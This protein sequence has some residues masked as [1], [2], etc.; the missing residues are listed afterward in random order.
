M[1]GSVTC[2]N[3][4]KITVNCNPVTLPAGNPA[5]VDGQL[6]ITVQSGDGTFEYD[7][8]TPLQFKAVSGTLLGDTVYNVSGDADLG[9]G[10]RT[11]SDLATLTVTSAEAG[12]FGFTAGPVEPK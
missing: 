9:A 1:P 2:N 12:G 5:N 7:P 4:S 3:E 10:V 8:A 6:T 11:I